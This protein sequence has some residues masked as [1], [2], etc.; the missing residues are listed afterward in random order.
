MDNRVMFFVFLIFLPL[1]ALKA[2]DKNDEFVRGNGAIA[3]VR[4]FF[5]CIHFCVKW[6]KVAGKKPI[7]IG[8]LFFKVRVHHI[9]QQR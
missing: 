7:E 2:M 3:L 5:N 1:T 9:S 6:H 4:L 8:F